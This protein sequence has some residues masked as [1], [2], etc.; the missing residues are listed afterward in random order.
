MTDATVHVPDVIGIGAVEACGAIRSAGLSPTGPQ[1][2]PEPIE[3]TIV[4]QEPGPDAVVRIGASVV[5]WSDS[6]RAGPTPLVSEPSTTAAP[7]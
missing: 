2:E 4:G 3:G 5:L 7:A 1:R 6:G